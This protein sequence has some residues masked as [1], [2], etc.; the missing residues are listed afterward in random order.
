MI[1]K[2]FS[3]YLAAPLT[4]IFNKALEEYTPLKYQTILKTIPKGPRTN[5]P[6][7]MRFI[8]LSDMEI[9]LF[10]KI[11]IGL[12]R[13]HMVENGIPNPNQYSGLK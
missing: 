6:N 10:Y 1:L 9:K 2:R 11:L 3:Q 7:S 8:S 12:I 13:E 5:M 4:D